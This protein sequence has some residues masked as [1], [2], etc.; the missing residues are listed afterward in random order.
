MKKYICSLLCLLLGAAGLASAQS[1]DA[2]PAQGTIAAL[3][4]DFLQQRDVLAVLALAQQPAQVG[5]RLDFG[6]ISAAH[7]PADAV[8]HDLHQLRVAAVP[9]RNDVNPKFNSKR[10]VQ[11][12]SHLRP[13]AE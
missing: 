4:G 8:R 6:S 1:P 12:R 2:V 11:D 13:R 7:R 9:K 10:K 5:Q 3:V